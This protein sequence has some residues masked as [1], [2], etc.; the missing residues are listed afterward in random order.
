MRV[1]ALDFE[2]AN[3]YLQSACSLGVSI[4]QDGEIMDS[5]E[6]YFKPHHRYNYFTNSHIHGI[7]LEDVIDE[8]EFVFYYEE[9]AT[10]LKDSVIVA[11]N[12]TFD[13][14]V[15]N[16]LCDLYGLDRLHNK[17]LDTVEISRKVYPELYNHKLNTVCDYLDIDLHHHNGQSDSMGCLMILL[18][19]ME[20]YHCY[21]LD[22][23]VRK[24]RIH[25]RD[26][27]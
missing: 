3:S 20:A 22:E 13:L 17:Y 24:V 4:Y 5:F 1:V 15:L 11:H 10:L 19:A 2:T 6:W 23:F 27:L 18:K 21:E 12:A 8:N 26:N 16:S 25:Y 7:V 14:G 9:L